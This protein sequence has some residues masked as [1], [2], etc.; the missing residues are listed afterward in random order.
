MNNSWLFSHL[1]L[2]AGF[3]LAALLLGRILRERRSPAATMAWLMAVVLVPYLGV[4]LYLLLGGRKMRRIAGGKA[5]VLLA[6]Q[7]GQP[8][9]EALPLDRILGAYGVPP[10]TGGNRIQ[11]Q[12]SGEQAWDALTGLI[13]RAE[14]SVYVAMFVLQHDAIGREILA[15]LARRAGEGLE[16]RLLLDGVGS[17]HTPSRFLG[18]LEEAGGRFAYF[19]PVLHRPFRSRTNLRNHRK[20]VIADGRVVLAGGTNIGGEYLGPEPSARR[21]RDLAFTIEGPA[22]SHYLEIFRADWFFASGE[23]LPAGAA[24]PRATGTA[25]LRVV[26][27][28]PDVSGDPLYDALLTAAFSAQERFWITTPYFV[29]DEALT[30]A[31]ILAARRGVDLRVIVPEHSNHRIADIAGRSYLRQIQESGGTVLFFRNGMLHAKAVLVDERLAFLGSANFDT[32]SLLLNYETAVLAYSAETVA[33][34]TAWMQ[35][36]A[37]ECR[38]GVA[39][40]GLVRELAHGVARLLAPQL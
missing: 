10:A 22:V 33:E 18:P 35:S 31:L 28:G 39:P 4:P 12:T 29:P 2:I 7:E 40:V 5:Q 34:V 15:R 21:W 17:L 27:S 9:V 6:P 20:T 16:V 3:L 37:D 32:R 1:A 11:L 13:D 23:R 8:P 24:G 14:K 19:N 38:A 36:I 30:R 26:P 25:L